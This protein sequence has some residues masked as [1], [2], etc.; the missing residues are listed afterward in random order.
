MV[1]YEKHP[2]QFID[3]VYGPSELFFFGIEKLITKFDLAYST[4]EVLDKGNTRKVNRFV[5]ENS[6][7]RWIDKRT[8]LEELGRIPVEVFIDACLLAGSSILKNF[9]PLSSPTL[10]N[11]G[12]SI[13]DVVNLLTSY[14][15]SVS[16]VCAQYSNDPGVKEIDYLDKYKKAITAIKHHIIITKDGDIETIDKEN[17]PLDVHDCIGQRLPEELNMYLSRGMIQPRV[18]NW[19]TSGTIRVTAP[20]DGGDSIVY[21]NLVK[22]KLEPMRRVALCLLADSIHRYYQR[23]EITTKLWFDQEFK[24]KIN[25]KDLLPSPKE[26]LSKWN[27]KLD[28]MLDQRRKLEVLT[29]SPSPS[30]YFDNNSNRLLR[31]NCYQAPFHLLFV[32]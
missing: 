3:A 19:L 14:S 18:L 23:K 5:L 1:Y 10:F 21:Q 28:V 29:T 17:A 13:R 4:Y 12:Y 25:I 31:R 22:T 27:V 16:Q 26:L 15:H 7:F 20:L 6:T 24:A 30:L 8:C 2:D 9:P 11:K 32:P